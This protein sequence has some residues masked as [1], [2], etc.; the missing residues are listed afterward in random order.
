VIEFIAVKIAA[1]FERLAAIFLSVGGKRAAPD[2]L[3]SLRWGARGGS[4][5]P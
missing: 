4:I 1:A 3:P 5:Q 2:W